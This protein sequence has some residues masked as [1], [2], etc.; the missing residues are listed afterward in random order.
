MSTRP[1]ARRGGLVLGLKRL[2]RLLEHEPGDLTATVEAGITLGRAPGR[3]GR[4]RPVALARSARRRAGHAGRHPRRQRLGPAPPSL[5]HRARPAD[6]P[7]RGHG[8]RRARAR[9]RQ[10]REERGRLRP[11][12]ALHR[13]AS[14]RSASSWRRRSSSA[15]ASTRTGWWSRASIALEGRGRGRARAAGLAT[16]FPPRS[17]SLDGEALR[18]RARAGAARRRAPGRLRR[19][20]P[21]RSQWQVRRAGAAARPARPGGPRVLTLPRATRSGAARRPSR[22]A[23]VPTAVAAVMRWS[24]LPTQ[25]AERD[26]RGRGGGAAARP[27]AAR[28]AAHAGVGMVTGAARGRR[29]SRARVGGR[30]AP[31]W[32]AAG[33]T[34]LG[35]RRPRSIEW[36]PLAV[37]A[38][39]PVWD[40]PGAGRAHHA[41]ASRPSSTRSGVLNPGRFVGGI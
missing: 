3:A 12:E 27:R 1:A 2:D 34:R 36:A 26:G 5:R 41:A 18:R 9:R 38:Q 29:A 31:T 17:S 25:V 30:A 16:S 33:A 37:K 21:S 10:G 4:A 14:A 40:A 39:V 13:L 15:R 32:R 24:V 35:G 8:R 6:R 20:R 11:P 22:R 28:A 23:R 19:H 7:H